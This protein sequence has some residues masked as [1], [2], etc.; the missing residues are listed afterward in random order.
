MLKPD[1]ST[2]ALNLHTLGW[3]NRGLTILQLKEST[4]RTYTLHQLRIE[5]GEA[6]HAGACISSVHQKR[7][8]FSNADST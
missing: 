6:E 5:A 1:G 8:Q 2:R 7:S 4:R 3:M